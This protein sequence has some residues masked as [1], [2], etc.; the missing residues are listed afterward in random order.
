MD[1]AKPF[2]GGG[3]LRVHFAIEG[4]VLPGDAGAALFG[5]DGWL[6]GFAVGEV[7]ALRREGEAFVVEKASYPEGYEEDET[8]SDEVLAMMR[9][10]KAAAE[11]D[12]DYGDPSVPGASGAEIVFRTRLAE[13]SAFTRP[14]PP[15]SGLLEAVGLEV[16]HGYVG[17][18]GTPWFGEPEWFDDRQREVW[19]DWSTALDAH[20]SN[21]IHAGRRGADDSRV[22]APRCRP[23]EFR[24]AGHPGRRRRYQ[25]RPGHGDG[26]E[27]PRARRT[28][29]SAGAGGRGRAQ[30]L[31]SGWICSSERWR[32]TPHSRDALG[33]L[34]DLRAVA[35]DAREAKR[36]YALAGVDGLAEDVSVLRPF[37][38]PPAGPGRNKPCPCGSGKKYK[39]CHGRTE[40]HPLGDRA[41]WLWHK[42]AMFAQ[43]PANREEL[44]EWGGLLAGRVPD[45]RGAVAKAM[46]DPT[47]LDFAVYDGGLLDDFLFVLGP[48]LPADEREL[49]E[50]G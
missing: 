12:A 21:G 50:A 38:D 19:R 47:T 18:P 32:P 11:F 26:G 10:A 45:D 17:L 6:D 16:V 23:G 48:M 30:K 8:Y 25:P 31:L 41:A 34:A 40:R 33:D 29:L 9:A 28:A 3:L 37:L 22:R 36:L 7:I 35:G 27:R 14:L 4:R 42:I 46:S 43:R 44:L 13:P 20:T 49:A 24:G 39:V 2:I 15:I 5:P 1:E